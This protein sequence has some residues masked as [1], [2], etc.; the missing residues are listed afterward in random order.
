MKHEKVMK[1][2]RE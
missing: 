2:A 1:E